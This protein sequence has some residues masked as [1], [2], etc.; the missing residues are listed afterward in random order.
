MA[1]R[2][3]RVT[4]VYLI[5]MFRKGICCFLVS[6]GRTLCKYVTFGPH[7]AL[8]PLL[9]R[10][11]EN[12]SAAGCLVNICIETLFAQGRAVLFPSGGSIYLTFLGGYLNHGPSGDVKTWVHIYQTP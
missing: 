6:R 1:Y 10:I 5:E 11:E 9:R 4:D 12:Y 3:Q 7:V 8:L 2:R